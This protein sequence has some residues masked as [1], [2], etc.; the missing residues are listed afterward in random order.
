MRAKDFDFHLPE[1]LIAQ[2]PLEDRTASRLLV[3]N[4]NTDSMKHT[5]FRSIVDELHEGD[6]LVVNSSRVL[7]ARLFGTK[8]DTGAHIELLLLKEIGDHTWETLAKPAKRLKVGSELTFGDGRLKAVCTG[9]TEDGGRL[10]QFQFEGIFL[11]LLEQLGDMPL[12]PYIREKLEDRERYQTVYAKTPGSAAAP[13]AGLHFT[14]QLLESLKAKGV[15]VAECTLHVGLGTFR[16]VSVDEVADHKMHSEWYELDA[17]NANIIQQ[18]KANGGRVVAVGTTSLR[19]LESIAA[20]HDGQ[21]VACS[22]WT[23]IFITPGYKFKAIDALITNFHLP[24]STLVMLVSAAIGRDFT[25]EVYE[26]AVREKYR[27]F[28]FGDAM[29]I[30]ELLKGK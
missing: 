21:V 15:Q 26:E 18:T 17:T 3:V 6:C 24:Q 11:E 29:Y 4:P 30:S 7:P 14:E 8:P 5:T 20:A 12:P 23:D 22:G 9:T 10:V 25:L 19:T 13:T 1:E 27:F 2:T 16:P 28:S